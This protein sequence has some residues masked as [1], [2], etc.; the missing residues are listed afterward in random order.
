GHQIVHL[1]PPNTEMLGGGNIQTASG[2]HGEGA[3]RSGDAERRSASRVGQAE[4]TFREGSD[5]MVE[6]S[7]EAR[8]KEIGLHG[9][10]KAIH[11]VTAEVSNHAKPIARVQRDFRIPSL[12]VEVRGVSHGGPGADV[13]VA[14]SD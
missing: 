7:I 9:R 14:Q 4:Q 5:A 12:H 1:T 3:S 10:I 8:T 6:W 2:R 13:G 11:V